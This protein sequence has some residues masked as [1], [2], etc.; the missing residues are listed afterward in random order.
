MKRWV[1]LACLLATSLVTACDGEDPPPV[2]AGGLDAL[3]EQAKA[4]TAPSPAADGE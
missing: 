1:L 3:W 2:D 4:Q